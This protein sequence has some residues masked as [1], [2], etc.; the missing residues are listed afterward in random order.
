MAKAKTNKFR[1]YA[2]ADVAKA[3]KA[4]KKLVLELHK[5]KKALMYPYQGPP[6][7]GPKCR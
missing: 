1:K 4:Q 7:Y 2:I 3:L 5:I 6:P